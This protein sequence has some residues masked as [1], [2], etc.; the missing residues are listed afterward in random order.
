M[1]LLSLSD[2]RVFVLLHQQIVEPYS[3]SLPEQLLNLPLL[4]VGIDHSWKYETWP[5]G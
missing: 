5:S 4:N 1:L 3:Q 2:W